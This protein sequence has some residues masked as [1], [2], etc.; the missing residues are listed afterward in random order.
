M[1]TFASQVIL[2]VCIER[3]LVSQKYSSDWSPPHLDKNQR[4]AL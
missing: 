2:K 1:Q 3:D 4:N